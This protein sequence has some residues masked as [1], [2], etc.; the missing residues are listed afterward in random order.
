MSM[1]A[2]PRIQSIQ[3]RREEG[4]EVTDESVTCDPGWGQGE[5]R[6]TGAPV[7]PLAVHFLFRALICWTR[8]SISSDVSL[9]AFLGMRPLPLVM[10][11]RRRSAE[12]A[13]VFSVMSAGPPKWRPSAV[14]P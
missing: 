8:V 7:S 1:Q 13:A 2:R 3:A 11:L 9:P 14:L 6:R 12:V 10:M 4:A 5:R